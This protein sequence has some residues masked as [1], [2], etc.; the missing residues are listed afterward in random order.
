VAK[1]TSATLAKLAR[2]SKALVGIQRR[3][4]D[5]ESE[6]QAIRLEVFAQVN[7]LAGEGSK[8]SVELEETGYRIGRTL[9]HGSP[10]L[11]ADK[12]REVIGDDLFERVTTQI[13]T[14]SID[15]A[16]LRDAIKAEEVTHSQIEKAIVPG[17][18]TERLIH[19]KIGS[20]QDKRE[21]ESEQAPPVK[22]DVEGLLEF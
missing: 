14:Y 4:K 21:Q 6:Y 16:A 19:S 18:T 13:V 7:R 12:L 8:L 11:D 2:F 9:Q 15:Y 5:A 1:I 10:S 22:S 20:A 3:K 17:R